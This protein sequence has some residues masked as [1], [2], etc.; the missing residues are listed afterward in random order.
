MLIPKTLLTFEK[1]QNSGKYT[2]AFLNFN[3]QSTQTPFN[4]TQVFRN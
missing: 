3:Q 2:V 4:I 1:I